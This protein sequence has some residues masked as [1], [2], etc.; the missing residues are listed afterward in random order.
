[1]GPKKKARPDGPVRAGPAIVVPIGVAMQALATRIAQLPRVVQQ[2][3][4]GLG[5]ARGGNGIG[6][7]QRA[8]GRGAGQTEAW[9][10]AL[11]YAA[12][13]REDGDALDVITDTFFISNVPYVALIDIGSTHSYVTCSVSQTLGIPRESTSSEILVVSPL[14]NGILGGSDGTSVWGVPLNFR[15]GLVGKAWSEKLVRKGYKAFLAYISV[16][17]SVDSSIKDIR[18]V[19]DFL[20]VFPKEL[21]GLPPSQE[22]EFGIELIPSI[23]L[24]SIAPYRMA[25]NELAELK[26][27]IQELL[28]HGFIHPSGSP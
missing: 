10:L 2:P 20:D 17:D 11:V 25:P 23:A 19:R 24:V 12:H 26:A 15:H 9:Q 5:Q 6:R 22:V 8:R 27:Q 13:R 21:L 16:S 1:M 28:D 3:P 18:T 14:G 4:R 7:G